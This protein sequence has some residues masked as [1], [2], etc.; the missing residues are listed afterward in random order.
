MA[1]LTGM[2]VLQHEILRSFN[3]GS[4][5]MQPMFLWPLLVASVIIVLVLIVAYTC[6]RKSRNQTENACK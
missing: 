6:I 1:L 3:D 4:Y 2:A 5:Y